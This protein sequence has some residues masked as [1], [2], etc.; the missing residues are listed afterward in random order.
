VAFPAVKGDCTI[1]ELASEYERPNH[2]YHWKKQL[3]VGEGK[4]FR[5]WRVGRCLAGGRLLDP[6]YQHM[7]QLKVEKREF[8]GTKARAK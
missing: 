5:G 8:F 6:L 1:A 7:G 4:C 3:L 2:I